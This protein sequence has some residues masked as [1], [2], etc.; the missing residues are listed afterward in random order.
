MIFRGQYLYDRPVQDDPRRAALEGLIALLFANKMAGFPVSP[1]MMTLTLEQSSPEE[2]ETTLRVLL[3]ALKRTVRAEFGL[4]TRNDKLHVRVI[5]RIIDNAPLLQEEDMVHFGNANASPSTKGGTNVEVAVDH[6]SSEIAPHP[7][8]WINT[9]DEPAT[10]SH[11]VTD[12]ITYSPV[13][14]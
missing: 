11:I 10:T 8:E 4:V 9:G 5:A 2:C 14:G 7:P 1:E 12:D 3:R 13:E 6:V